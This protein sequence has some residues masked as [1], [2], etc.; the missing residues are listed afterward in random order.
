[1]AKIERE[2]GALTPVK[3]L[4]DKKAGEAGTSGYQM[5]VKKSTPVATLTGYILLLFG[6]KKIGKTSMLAE[7]SDTF[8][9]FFEPGGKA[10][11]VFGDNFGG[12]GGWVRFRAFVKAN[13]LEKR[14]KH[15][16]IDTVDRAY[17]TS[18]RYTLK[19]LEIEHQSEEAYGKGWAATREDFEEPIM[20]LVNA[21]I[22]VTF[23][24]HADEREITRLD[25]AKYDKIAPTMPKQARELIEG[26]VDIWAF[27]GYDGNK[28]VLTI[29]G[30]DHIAAGHRLV[31]HFRA[32]DGKPL[33][34]IHMGVSAA[35]AWKNFNDAFHNRYTPPAKKK[36]VDTD[37]G[38]IPTFKKKT[39]GKK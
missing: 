15:V 12:A 28:R 38:A 5:P 9:A 11:S 3:K 17:K 36:E 16:V 37:D 39:V 29:Q 13:L 2:K 4:A 30:D 19:R 8:F 23:I 26:L 14:F 10:L 7:D 24:S 32:P 35:E 25:G 18:E 6:E 22:A 31:N 20:Q 27:Y 34:Q 1:M 33:R 21:G